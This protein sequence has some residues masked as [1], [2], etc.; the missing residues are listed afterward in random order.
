MVRGGLAKNE[1]FNWS[2]QAYNKA[3]LSE[4][5]ELLE[6]FGL[7]KLQA[8]RLSKNQY[9]TNEQFNW[10]KQAYNKA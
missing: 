5:P 7:E 6:I 3:Q 1:Q 8:V 2:K 4:G 10:S 9:C